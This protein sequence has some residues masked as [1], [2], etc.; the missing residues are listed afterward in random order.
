MSRLATKAFTLVELLVVIAI[1]AILASLLLPALSAAKARAQAAQCANNLRQLGQATFFY[2]DEQ[3]DHLPFAWCNDP[4]PKANS[5]YALLS[6]MLLGAEFDGYSDFE[7]RVFAC[8]TRMKESLV[9]PNPMRV[10]YGMNA[11]NSISF[12]DPMTRRLA[13][14]QGAS[15]VVKV[16]VADIDFT[17]NHPPLQTLE[18]SEVGYKHRQKAN[19]FFFDAHVATCSLRQ[20]NGL[21]MRY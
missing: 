14:A 10:S 11:N 1:I 2:C 8:P 5:F 17:Y 7:R 4:D 18:K 19:I 6:P 13:D 12:P 21:V 15:C 9:G 20:T 3:D 16:L